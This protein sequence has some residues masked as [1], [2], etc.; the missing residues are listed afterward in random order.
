M[1]KETK[2]KNKTRKKKRSKMKG[3]GSTDGNFGTLID[4]MFSV[5]GYTIQ[6]F[7]KTVGVAKSAWNLS[8]DLNRP[9]NP[10]HSNTPGNNLG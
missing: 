4:D 2:N 7:T 10:K 3:G 8:T 1:V 6:S 9:Y 5:V